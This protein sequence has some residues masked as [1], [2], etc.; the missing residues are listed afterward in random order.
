F[1]SVF[2]NWFFFEDTADIHALTLESLQGRYV[3]VEQIRFAPRSERPIR[4]STEHLLY[5]RFSAAM[6]G[7]EDNARQLNLRPLGRYSLTKTKIPSHGNRGNNQ[8]NVD[9]ETFD[10]GHP[11]QFSLRLWGI[12]R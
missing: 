5:V 2:V 8:Q 6:I 11:I 9:R 10:D 4:D 3:P 7:S 1:H 12:A